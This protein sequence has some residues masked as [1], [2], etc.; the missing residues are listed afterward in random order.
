MGTILIDD[1][2]AIDTLNKTDKKAEG[3]GGKLLG[4]GK[5]AVKGAAILGGAT[6]AGGTALLGMAKKAADTTDRIDKM[7]QKVGLSR[8]GFQEWVICP[9]C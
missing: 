3:V 9:V 1:K 5:S 7:S 8:K 6:L 2:K 4:M